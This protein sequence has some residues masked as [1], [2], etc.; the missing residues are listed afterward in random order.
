VIDEAR[1]PLRSGAGEGADLVEVVTERTAFWSGLAE[2]EGRAVTVDLPQHPV[3]TPLPG[4]DART[5]LDVLLDNAFR[6][7][8]TGTPVQVEV[9]EDGDEVLLDVADDG[10]GFPAGVDVMGRGRS[11]GGGSGLGLDIARRTVVR[12]GGRIELDRTEPSG[13]ARI[14]CVLPRAGGA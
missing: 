5:V 7:T 14:R 12:A 8:P 3:R 11:G 13:G 1:A 10:P 6:H 4:S 9:R 2:D